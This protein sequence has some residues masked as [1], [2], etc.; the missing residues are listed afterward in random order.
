VWLATLERAGRDVALVIADEPLATVIG[1]LYC[2]YGYD[3]VAPETPLAVIQTLLSSGGQIGVVIIS[4]DA[5]W[6][7]GFREFL[8][9]EY[10]EID[11]LVL[12]A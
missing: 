7:H 11:R 8:A 6:A 5:R 1:E 2:D 10:P 4:P 3:A 9:D 12:A